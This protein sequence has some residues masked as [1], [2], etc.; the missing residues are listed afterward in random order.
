MDLQRSIRLAVD[1]GK[2]TLG[3]QRTIQHALHGDAK[4]V[5]IAKN[6]P[7]DVAKD[8]KHYCSLS[9]VR[10]LDFNGTSIELGTVCGK[11]FPVSALSVVNEGDS[12]IL[13]QRG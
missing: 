3:S 4:L 5:V 13:T 1:S 12:D 10:V 2:V 8:L 11:P 6:C 7:E 9:E